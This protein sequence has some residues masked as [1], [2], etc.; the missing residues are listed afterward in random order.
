MNI[1]DRVTLAAI[2]ATAVA[3]LF[4]AP[5]P[6]DTPAT[7][8]GAW[9]LL[10]TAGALSFAAVFFAIPAPAAQPAPAA[11]ALPVAVTGAAG[12]QGMKPHIKAV[13]MTCHGAMYGVYLGGELIAT[14]FVLG[15]MRVH[16]R[17]AKSPADLLRNFNR[18]HHTCKKEGLVY[19]AATF[20]KTA[21]AIRRAI[22]NQ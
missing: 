17:G 18:Q 19:T 3:V 16:F 6:A 7:D 5:L 1:Q 22:A 9:L 2:I 8:A 10:A 13:R 12:Y 20:R 4:T 21:T 15:A 11:P 14:Y